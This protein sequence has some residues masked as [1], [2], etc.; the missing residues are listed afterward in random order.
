MPNWVINELYC[1]HLQVISQLR[2]FNRIVPIP[3]LLE[4]TVSGSDSYHFEQLYKQK[5]TYRE[6]LNHP[7]CYSTKDETGN[8]VYAPTETSKAEWPSKLR[9]YYLCCKLYGYTTWYEWRIDNWGCKW[10]ASQFELIDDGSWCRFET[11]WAHP[12]PLIKAL[13]KA[14]PDAVINACFADENIG[15]NSGRYIIQNGEY[16]VPDDVEELSREAYEIAFEL[17]GCSDDYRWDDKE[18]SYIFIG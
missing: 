17:W 6:M 11:P 5:M 18:C 1:E 4:E 7:P 14:Y 2:D 8:T 9:K 3:L 15:C 16:L 12:F 10:N 13:S